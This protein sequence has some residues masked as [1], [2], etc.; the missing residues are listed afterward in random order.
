M[1]FCRPSVSCGV[2]SIALLVAMLASAPHLQ[3]G[4]TETALVRAADGTLTS[5]T[6]G[7][8]V[9][10]PVQV[11]NVQ[12]LGA[13]TVLVGYDP[14]RLKAVACQRNALFDVGL[15][16]IAYD[17][18]SDGTPDAVLFNVVSLLG[19]SATNTPI[20]LANITWQAVA[21][22]ESTQFTTL[23][24][25]V[26]TFTDTD[27]KPLPYTAQDGQLTLLPPP[28]TPTPSPTPTFT[29]TPTVTST[30]TPTSTATPTATSIATPTPTA[31]HTATATSTPTATPPSTPTPGKRHG[32]LP[33]LLQTY[34]VPPVPTPTPTASGTPTL[35]PARM[36]TCSNW[37]QPG[38][39]IGLWRQTVTSDRPVAD[40]RGY[41]N[42]ALI[43]LVSETAT[44][45]VIEAPAGASARIEALYGGA[46]LVA[47][48]SVAF[49]EP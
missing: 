1:S 40:W 48:K 30:P 10:L 24:V 14:T 34:T 47:C 35:E 49:C 7:P 45:A 32:Y 11:T 19:V 22:V 46:W 2:L 6:P 38:S 13:A 28:P 9:V 4:A 42:F 36:F 25:Q 12:A 23:A 20:T 31:T 21:K 16:N 39:Q 29:A 44:T 43:E 8:S 3:A 41:I 26:Q 33:L 5:G 27:G 15:C 37:C 18:N 17:R